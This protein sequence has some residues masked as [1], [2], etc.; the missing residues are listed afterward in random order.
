MN[1]FINEYRLMYGTFVL[2]H[3][4]THKHALCKTKYT[5]VFVLS[6]LYLSLSHSA[7][8]AT[9]LLLNI[10]FRSYDINSVKITVKYLSVAFRK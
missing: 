3:T 6:C 2:S 7:A 4:Y 8:A 10:A 1:E 5:F 9:S